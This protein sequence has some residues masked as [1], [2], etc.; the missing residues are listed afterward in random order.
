MVYGKLLDETYN[1]YAKNDQN[2]QKWRHYEVITPWKI[3]V[4]QFQYNFQNP[5]KISNQ[6]GEVILSHT[7]YSRLKT[8]KVHL[9]AI[10]FIKSLLR[11]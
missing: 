5:R 8:E 6:I 1:I 7:L 10:S 2:D 3:N 9:L 4:E 11:D